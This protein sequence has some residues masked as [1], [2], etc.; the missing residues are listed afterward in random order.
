M[1]KR[2]DDASAPAAERAAIA[3]A[4]AADYGREEPLHGT[5][6]E[7]YAVPEVR[8]RAISSTVLSVTRP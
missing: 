6:R 1:K 4:M 3:V 7:L 5:I 8:A 2:L